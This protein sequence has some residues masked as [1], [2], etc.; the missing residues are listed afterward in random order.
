MREYMY[1]CAC[2]VLCDFIP[3][4]HVWLIGCCV[5][6]KTETPMPTAITNVTNN[7]DT[8]TITTTPTISATAT[9]VSFT[10][11]AVLSQG[12]NCRHCRRSCCFS[13]YYNCCCCYI[14]CLVVVI[15]SI[16]QKQNKISINANTFNV[17][18]L[19]ALRN[20]RLTTNNTTEMG[21]VERE[22]VSN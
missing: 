5:T 15:L 17:V 7:S 12:R 18:G 13:C 4:G 14:C 21:D 8:T 11:A 6:S 3:Q 10:V 16:Q 2:V 9:V 19:W 22:R 1:M 20:T